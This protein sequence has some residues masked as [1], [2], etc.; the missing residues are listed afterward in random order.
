[1]LRIRQQVN[2]EEQHFKVAF[3]IHEQDDGK[4]G[5][6]IEPKQPHQIKE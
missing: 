3:R 5:V 2:L 1:M 6:S 4:G